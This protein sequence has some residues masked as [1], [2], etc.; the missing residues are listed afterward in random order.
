MNETELLKEINDLSD[1]I[2][3]GEL[4]PRDLKES[5]WDTLVEWWDWWPGWTAPA[6]DFL[7]ENGTGG[8]MVEKDNIPIV[9]G[10]IY[11]TN[12]KGVLLE[13]IVSNPN[14][15]EN[16]RKQAIELLIK[17]AEGLT[18]RLGYKYMFTIGRS[19]SLINTHKKLGWIVDDKPSHEITKKLI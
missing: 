8:I 15:R 7:P 16:D 4:F 19:K 1:Q 12:S 2:K 14:Y 13:W 17:E 10:F 11:V 6:K 3:T 18:K 9:A 5:D